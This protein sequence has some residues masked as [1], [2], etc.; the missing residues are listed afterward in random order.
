[1][2]VRVYTPTVWE[3]FKLTILDKAV[4]LAA[5]FLPGPSW[6]LCGT[7]FGVSLESESIQDS[8]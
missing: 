4:W 3:N 1:M 8:T 5:P 2:G 7:T 6:P